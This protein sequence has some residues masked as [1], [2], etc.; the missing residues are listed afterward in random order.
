MTTT[1]VSGKPASSRGSYDAIDIYIEK[2]MR[3]LHIP[4]VALAVI[5]GGEIVHQ[6]GFGRAR[7]RGEPPTPQ[8]PFFIGSLTK[9]FTAVAVL[10][11][12]EAGKVVLDAPVQRYLPWFRVADPQAS[13]QITVRH[14]LNQTSGLP[15]WTGEI[16]LSDGDAAADAA[17][18]QVR[19]LATLV[20]NRPV[21]A[22][23]EYSNSNYQVLGLIIEAA[24][25]ESYASYVQKHIFDPL[26]MRHSYTARAAAQRDGLATGHQYW[27][28]VP[29]ARP[30]LPLPHG[31]LAGGL[32][33]SSA[34]D[35]ARYLT[36]LLDGGRRG[37]V[38]ILSPQ[39]VTELARGVAAVKVYG[40]SLGHYGMGWWVDQLGA[41]K[42]AWHSGTLP[43]F[44]GYM[45]LIPEQKKGVVL[46]VNADHHWMNPVL[47]TFGAGVTAL[48]AGERSQSVPFVGMIPWM[49][50][51]QLL[52]PLLQIVGSMTTLGLLRR[53]CQAPESRPRERGAWGRYLLL[54]LVPDLL[55]ALMLKPLLG[56]RRGYLRLYMPDYTWI[57]LICGS[58]ALMSHLLHAGLILGALRKPGGEPR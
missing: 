18:R 11:L 30:D 22:A 26:D 38:R 52:I 49:L 37:D 51:G 57:A 39:S 20:L 43:D 4:A 21:G 8:T 36:A 1:T 27:F 32:L 40:L 31:A 45:A 44:F 15:T 13:A 14:L 12:V 34:E 55:V 54:S 16:V 35:V 42:V 23:W 56:R 10:Q 47:T 29:I 25:G 9:S 5:D 3:R 33:I 2:E 28:G 6:R 58:L 19:D 41:T 50:R 48:L 46:L 7:P 17:E 24:S 53:G